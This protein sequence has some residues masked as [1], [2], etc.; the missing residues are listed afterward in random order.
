LLFEFAEPDL[1]RCQIGESLRRPRRVGPVK[2]EDIFLGGVVE[3]GFE[4]RDFLGSL[5]KPDYAVAV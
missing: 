5:K 2:D 3:C 4:A 1:K